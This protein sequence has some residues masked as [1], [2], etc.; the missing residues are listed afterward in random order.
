MGYKVE[1]TPK[2]TKQFAKMDNATKKRLQ[3]FLLKLQGLDNPRA[4]GKALQGA[5]SDMWRYRMGDYR[6]LTRI[7][8]DTLIVLVVSLDH[9][10]SVYN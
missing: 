2:A 1:F 4:S 6:I 8:D 9:R 3:D 5:L 10:S 7:I